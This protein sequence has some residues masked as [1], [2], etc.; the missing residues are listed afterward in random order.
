[1]RSP[2]PRPVST[3]TTKKNTQV[4]S[5][6]IIGSVNECV[7]EISLDS[8]SAISL[9]SASFFYQLN[10]IDHCLSVSSSG[11]VALSVTEDPVD[12]LCQVEFVVQL[13]GMTRAD[14]YIEVK[15]VFKV[16]RS[17]MYDCLLGI[18]L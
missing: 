10:E 18:D 1:M 3:L 9:I 17:I 8:G 12:I 16:A 13:Y 7:T 6:G 15:Q 5:N 11:T 4:D 14:A 2:S